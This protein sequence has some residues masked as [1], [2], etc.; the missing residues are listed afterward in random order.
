[1]SRLQSKVKLHFRLPLSYNNGK[2]IPNQEFIDAKNY[3]ISKYDGLTVTG[4]ATGYWKHAEMSY[5][6]ETVEYFVLI[7]EKT[8]DKKVK[9]GISKEISKFKKQFKQLE[10]LCY[11][12]T[13]MST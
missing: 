9:S 11:Y 1:M 7:K 5:S 8:F 4:I 12:H 13:V 2:P 6:D 3:F 10:I